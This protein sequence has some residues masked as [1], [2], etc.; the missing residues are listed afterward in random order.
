MSGMRS[1]RILVAHSYSEQLVVIR[2]RV[3]MVFGWSSQQQTDTWEEMAD[4]RL[5][6]SD[7]REAVR[8]NTLHEGMRVCVYSQSASF[9]PIKGARGGRSALYFRWSSSS[10]LRSFNHFTCDV[11]GSDLHCL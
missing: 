6:T 8:D 2:E 10:P 5:V 9:L 3:Q 4:G 1:C 7:C 11:W